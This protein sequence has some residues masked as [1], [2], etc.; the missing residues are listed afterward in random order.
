LTSG[1]RIRI[2]SKPGFARA[3]A[4]DGAKMR[5]TAFG[6]PPGPALPSIAPGLHGRWLVS[7]LTIILDDR[8]WVG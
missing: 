3:A 5:S 2:T 1:A 8:G 6:T 4:L 7:S